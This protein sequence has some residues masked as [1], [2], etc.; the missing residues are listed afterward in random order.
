[1]R[2]S[3]MSLSLFEREN[4]YFR[5]GH[6]PAAL[7]V[8]AELAVGGDER[9]QIKEILKI[10]VSGT[11]KSAKKCKMVMRWNRFFGNL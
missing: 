7:S 1:M 4:V 6:E 8:R 11:A 5:N 3:G 9:V 2:G 10:M